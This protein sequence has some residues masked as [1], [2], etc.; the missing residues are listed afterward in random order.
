[1]RIVKN[2]NFIE[3]RERV[4]TDTEILQ[5]KELLLSFGE[6][7]QSNLGLK[8]N[9][10]TFSNKGIKIRDVCGSFT[11]SG[12][13]YSIL[14]KFI[15][16]KEE[17]ITQK[18]FKI[19]FDDFLY[20]CKDLKSNMVYITK[21]GYY[22]EL[23]SNNLIDYLAAIYIN[24][25]EEAIEKYPLSW[26]NKK[27]AA[28]SYVKGK[29]LIEKEIKKLGMYDGKVW[30]S[31]SSFQE[32]NKF[33]SLLIWACEYFRS[34]LTKIATIG[35]IEEI[36]SYYVNVD[37][38]ILS[39][40]LVRNLTLPRQYGDYE[41]AFNIAKGLYLN[42]SFGSISGTNNIYGIVL[43]TERCFQSFISGCCSAASRNL[44]YKHFAQKQKKLAQSIIGVES[45]FYTIPDDIVVADSSTIILD[46]KYKLL[47][48]SDEGGRSR[49]KGRRKPISQDFYQMISSCISYDTNVAVMLYPK[50]ID[51]PIIDTNW[52]VINPV[53]NKYINIFAIPIDLTIC[54]DTKR[55]RIDLVHKF[56][57]TINLALQKLL[58]D[59]V[60]TLKRK[61]E[62][63][64]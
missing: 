57:A 40:S 33:N 21:K 34:K 28:L 48:L 13:Q 58:S 53:N 24:S 25:L 60:D 55:S 8:S 64:G 29:I 36:M 27:V 18:S 15:N 51:S 19:A 26:Y 63:H 46:A 38:N 49:E 45:S 32:N 14:P 35:H 54:D 17:D 61:E 43:N 5:Q 4:V 56:E 12:I 41:E 59:Q 10:I 16:I 30:C 52:R 23:W 7:L 42:A 1:M 20:F 50:A 44:G 31:Y 6:E 39:Y 22:K 47:S 37:T 2:I 62:I 9:P 11:I 3:G